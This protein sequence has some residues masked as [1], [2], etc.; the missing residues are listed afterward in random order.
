MTSTIS[1]RHTTKPEIRCNCT[2]WHSSNSA[3]RLRAPADV[4]LPECW[5]T[6]DAW[7]RREKGVALKEAR[8]PLILEALQAC[9]LFSSA[10]PT[11]DLPHITAAHTNVSAEQGEG[12]PQGWS[13]RVEELNERLWLACQIGDV[14]VVNSAI[15]DGAQIYSADEHGWTALHFAASANHNAVLQVN[16]SRSS[17]FFLCVYLVWS[18]LLSC[19]AT[20]PQ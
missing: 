17:F 8:R 18:T 6:L 4:S 5:Q 1:Q 19:S 14:G 15:A 9:Q 7:L 20:R 12:G 3:A 16:R 13:G 11:H 10:R 2:E